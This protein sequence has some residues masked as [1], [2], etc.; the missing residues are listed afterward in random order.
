VETA[1]GVECAA[2]VGLGLLPAITAVDEPVPVRVR[3][4]GGFVGCGGPARDLDQ[5]RLVAGHDLRVAGLRPAVALIPP[6]AVP[7]PVREPLQPVGRARRGA[8]CRRSRRGGIGLDRRPRRVTKGRILHEVDGSHDGERGDHPVLRPEPPRPPP[9]PP[10]RLGPAL[11]RPPPVPFLLAPA[12]LCAVLLEPGPPDEIVVQRRNRGREI[13]VIERHGGVLRE[14][15][16]PAP[17]TGAADIMFAGAPGFASRSP[18]AASRFDRLS[19]FPLPAVPRYG[20]DGWWEGDSA[21][22]T[23]RSE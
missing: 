10:D 23:L 17:S 16:K 18:A 12:L 1:V 11:L 21:N 6:H 14:R 13:L 20:P 4:V 2:E 5:V 22:T 15:A 8:R 3:R 9:L 19:R 7:L